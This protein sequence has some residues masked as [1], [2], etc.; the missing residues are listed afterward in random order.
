MTP[1]EIKVLVANIITGAGLLLFAIS[2]LFKSKKKT[3][4]L[5][6]INHF[7]FMIGSELILKA[8]VGIV[9]DLISGI[10]NLLVIF[11][12]N[13]KK[14]NIIVICVGFIVSLMAFVLEVGWNN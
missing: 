12:K 2:C 8:Y 11:D 14:V 9:T 5:Q 3:L 10:R 13:T 6:T 4:T 1:E 7:G